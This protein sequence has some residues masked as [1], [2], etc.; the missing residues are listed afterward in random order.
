MR[1]GW[2]WDRSL[3]APK[4]FGRRMR[5][6]SER[7]RTEG[8]VSVRKDSDDRPKGFGRR[9]DSGEGLRLWSIDSAGRSIN[10]DR[11]PNHPTTCRE[12]YSLPGSRLRRSLFFPVGRPGV[13]GDRSTLGLFWGS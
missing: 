12:F 4:G 8:G 5:N 7:I 2:T 10:L 11:G 1:T 3:Y 13:G 9:N 6:P